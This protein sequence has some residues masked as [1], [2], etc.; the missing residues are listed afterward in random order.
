MLYS[1]KLGSIKVCAAYFFGKIGCNGRLFVF[2]DKNN[3]FFKKTL[4]YF[5]VGYFILWKSLSR[6]VAFL[7]FDSIRKTIPIFSRC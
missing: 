4:F 1:K 2:L 3:Y 6:A 7:F 5:F